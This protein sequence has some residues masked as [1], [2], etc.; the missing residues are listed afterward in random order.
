MTKAITQ[1]VLENILQSKQFV[2]EDIPSPNNPSWG[3]HFK[4][5]N[6]F[7]RIFPNQNNPL[8]RVF[9]TPKQFRR[10]FLNQNDL[11]WNIRKKFLIVLF[12]TSHVRFGEIFD[13]LIF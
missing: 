5:K 9:I 11:I 8:W 4:Q 3:I 13:K 1:S 7:R 6:Q 10:I 12:V 2:L